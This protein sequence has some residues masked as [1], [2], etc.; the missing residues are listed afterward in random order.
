MT[1]EN[2]LTFGEIINRI[3]NTD[4]DNYYENINHEYD[5]VETD[6]EI[7]LSILMA[8]VKKNDINVDVTDGILKI[9]SERKKDSNVNYLTNKIIYGK[10]I[11]KFKL[12]KNID[13]N[14]INASLTDGVLVLTIPKTDNAKSKSIEIK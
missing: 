4:F 7:M 8:G 13:D 5:V 1:N 12:P 11:N 6:N 2:L 14:N 10:F 9:S 3:L